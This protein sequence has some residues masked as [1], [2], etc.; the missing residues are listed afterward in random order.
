MVDYNTMRDSSTGI[1]KALGPLNPSSLM[2][3]GM[4]FGPDGETLPAVVDDANGG[5]FS[6]FPSLADEYSL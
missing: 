3:F 2:D 1:Q 4:D 5:S 6:S